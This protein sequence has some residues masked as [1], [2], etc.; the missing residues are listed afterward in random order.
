MNITATREENERNSAM[1]NTAYRSENYNRKV[2]LT[3]NS[4]KYDTDK[5]DEGP[6]RK[7]SK[8]KRFKPAENPRL[9]LGPQAGVRIG[10]P[11]GIL[12]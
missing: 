1:A 11:Q 7:R 9:V 4:R 8:W 6:T 12:D 5:D 3:V 2:S 10:P